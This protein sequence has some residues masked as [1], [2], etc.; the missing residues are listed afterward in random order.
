MNDSRGHNLANDLKW[1]G[2]AVSYDS[3]RF[4]YF[5]YMQKKLLSIMDLRG[6][7]NFLDVGCGTGWAVCYVSRLLEGK[8]DFTG[9][10]I[11]EGMIDKAVENS[12]DLKNV[13]FYNASAEEIPLQSDY[14]DIAI[15]TNS[16]HHYL[17]PLKALRE[18]RRV[19]KPEGKLYILD[20]TADDFIV[21]WIDSLVRKREKEH[22]RF[23]GSK[24]YRAMFAEVSLT[25]LKSKIIGGYPLRAHIAMK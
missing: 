18:M 4:D 5:R 12:R 17:N 24:E 19:L 2:R 21:R 9:I 1:S 6:N 23:Y 13:R 3:R 7:S 20:I 10:D 11:S 25:Y 22:V 14:F 16:F 8:G 15:C